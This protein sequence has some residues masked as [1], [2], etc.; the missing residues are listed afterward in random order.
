MLQYNIGA[1]SG[2]GDR[3]VGEFMYNEIDFPSLPFSSFFSPSLS[4]SLSLATATAATVG[5]EERGGEGDE[6]RRGG[7]GEVG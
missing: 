2:A 4:L 3:E 6:E 1:A 7:E 5:G